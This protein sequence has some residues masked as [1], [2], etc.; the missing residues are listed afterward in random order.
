MRAE[1]FLLKHSIFSTREFARA[2]HMRIDSA[3]RLLHNYLNNGILEKISRGIWYNK[4]NKY[5]SIFGLVPYLLGRE[6]GY[7]SFLS[8]LH[9]HGVISQIPQTVF[10][11]TT[12]HARKIQ[13]NKILFEFIQLKPQFM[14]HGVLWHDKATPYAI[15]SIEKA[16]I[17]CLYISTR[18]GNRFQH[19]PEIDFTIISKKK[20]SDLLK[21]H[22][23]TSTI[24]SCIK[25]RLKYLIKLYGNPKS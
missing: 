14:A 4:E 24:E 1:Q 19:F 17:D 10:I 13:S 22:Q 2:T 16:L 6:Q 5:Y 12:G 21:K 23:F 7:V 15:A 20:L 25:K 3:S 11:A 9:R 18:K 8:A